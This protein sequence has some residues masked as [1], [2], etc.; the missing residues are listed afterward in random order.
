ML[1]IY[2]QPSDPHFL[3]HVLNLR[4]MSISRVGWEMETKGGSLHFS[5]CRKLLMHSGTVPVFTCW[6][7]NVL[8]VLKLSSL[9]LSSCGLKYF[10]VI[11][12]FVCFVR[13]K[14]KLSVSSNCK[15]WIR[16]FENVLKAASV[17]LCRP[18][19]SLEVHVTAKVWTSCPFSFFFSLNKIRFA[20]TQCEF[21]DYE[22]GR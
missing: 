3:S 15:E 11:S 18:N 13:S 2:G 9:S 20:K 4:Q 5:K 1:L 21:R 22:L 17:C 7:T 6:Y 10:I 14:F 8:E 19:I 12:C 16:V